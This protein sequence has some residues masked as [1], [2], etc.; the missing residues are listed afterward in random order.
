IGQLVRDFG[1]PTAALQARTLSG[2]QASN[3]FWVTAT[4]SFGA[5]ALL[6]VFAP[7]IV[8]LYDEPR[9][10][11]IVPVMACGLVLS[12]LQAQ[13]HV[14]LARD[15]RFLALTSTTI[16]ARLA[17]LGAGVLGALLG[18]EYWALVT[19]LL[20]TAFVALCSN[21]VVTRWIPSRPRRGHG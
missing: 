4:L 10:A 14:R 2:Q 18:W 21:I 5:S 11:A 9:L 20:V 7:L 19:Q 3:V 6:V 1:M 12:G 13:Y 17:G 16:A 15:M 8:V